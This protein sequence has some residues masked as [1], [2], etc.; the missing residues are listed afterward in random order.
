MD[1]ATSRLPLE[2][3]DDSTNLEDTLKIQAVSSRRRTSVL[4]KR[5]ESPPVI[6]DGKTEEEQK[7]SIQEAE[8]Q[9]LEEITASLEEAN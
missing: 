4:E 8:T 9:E 3:Q 6:V 2:Q 7:F 5:A 1:D